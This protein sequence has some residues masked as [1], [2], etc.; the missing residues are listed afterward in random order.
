[1]RPC[2][3]HLLALASEHTVAGN[4]ARRA[5]FLVCQFVPSQRIGQCIKCLDYPFLDYPCIPS[6]S[7]SPD[8]R[9]YTALHSNYYSFTA[10]INLSQ[11]TETRSC[12]SNCITTDI[13][14]N[15]P[16]LKIPLYRVFTKIL[17]I[18]FI[19]VVSVRLHYLMF[20]CLRNT[21]LA[22]QFDSIACKE[23]VLDHRT[24]ENLFSIVGPGPTACIWTTFSD[25][26][27]RKTGKIK[28]K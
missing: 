24:K 7:I 4:C 28:I 27:G 1:V 23:E 22:V 21:V 14:T 3:T 25:S 2:V 15:H 16:C 19:N 9:E 20:E 8:N 26:N 5:R 12:K 13:T 11:L 10:D 18:L 6:P 17:I